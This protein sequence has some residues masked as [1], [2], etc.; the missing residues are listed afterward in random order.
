DIPVMAMVAAGVGVGVG[1][2]VG[3][4]GDPLLALLPLPQPESKVAPK[5]ATLI[6]RILKRINTPFPEEVWKEFPG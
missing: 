5:S 3:G 4:S 2:G 1:V 6:K